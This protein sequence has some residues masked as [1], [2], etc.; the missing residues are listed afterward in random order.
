[1]IQQRHVIFGVGP[2]GMA[3]MDALAAQ[4]QTVVLVNRSGKVK[5]PLPANVTTAAA[6]LNDPAQV[7]QLC[8]DAQVVYFCAMPPYTDWPRLF[9]PMIQGLL[10]GLAGSDARLVYGDNLYMYGPT[11]GKPLREDLPYAAAG[12]KGRL[13]AELAQQLFAAHQAG[14]VK[15][16]IGRASDFYGPCAFNAHLGDR[17]FK[18]A[19]AG[20]PVDVI[21]NPDQPHTYTFIRDYAR[22]LVT[23][24]AHDEALGQAWHIP[25]AEAITPR[26][27]IA[28]VSTE[29]GQPLKVRAAG[30]L[31][32]SVLGLFDPIMRELKE[33]LYQ[34]EKPYLVDHS[35]FAAAF[36]AN[37]TSH[38]V[39]V[40]ETVAWF[41]S[42]LTR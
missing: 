25:S 17:F 34:W 4:G 22:G 39:A 37:P 15:V 26:Q 14:K 11:D 19:F 1:M 5:Q 6:D 9:P 18:A 10:G 12:H 2:L 38:P 30:R 3:V 32:V 8:T 36:G 41:R 13:R 42:N 20:K 35:K 40:R 27:L 31:L 28:L 16:T 24:G 21:G 7:R 29:V 33:T 23:L